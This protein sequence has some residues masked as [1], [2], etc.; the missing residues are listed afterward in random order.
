MRLENLSYLVITLVVFGL[1]IWWF[2]IYIIPIL[3]D[4]FG[5]TIAGIFT[6]ILILLLL[7]L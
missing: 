4:M 7:S 2:E 6:L 5:T 3:G 1:I